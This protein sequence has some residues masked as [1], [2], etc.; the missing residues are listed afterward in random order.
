VVLAVLQVHGI[1]RSRSA[2]CSC[3]RCIVVY[4]AGT[5]SL[6]LSMEARK[7]CDNKALAAQLSVPGSVAVLPGRSLTGL[8]RQQV[9]EHHH[10]QLLVEIMTSMVGTQIM[11]LPVLVY[12]CARGNQ[13]M[14][15]KGMLPHS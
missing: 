2:C 15:F 11:H 14:R 4:A 6:S 1:P 12:A 8:A 5:C 13:W 9:C 3:C 10:H 7:R